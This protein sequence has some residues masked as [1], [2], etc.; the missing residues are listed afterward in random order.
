MRQKRPGFSPPGLFLFFT[1]ELT[2]ILGIT[3]R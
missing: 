1:D 3:C 2:P